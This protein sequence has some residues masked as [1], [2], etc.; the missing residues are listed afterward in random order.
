M[1]R[2]S[3]T[4]PPQAVCPDPPTRGRYEAP[5][6]AG[7]RSLESITLSNPPALGEGVPGS[8]TGRFGHP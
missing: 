6:L 8:G 3:T 1:T 4:V 7:K 5:R 2:P